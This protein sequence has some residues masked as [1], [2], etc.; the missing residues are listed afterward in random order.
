MIAVAALTSAFLAQRERAR[1]TQGAKEATV[2]L[3]S[4]V[5]AE[6]KSSLT[7][8]TAMASLRSSILTICIRSMPKQRELLRPSRTGSQLFCWHPPASS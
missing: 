2:A 7:T 4:A 5:D 3:L 6:L 8:L 1:F